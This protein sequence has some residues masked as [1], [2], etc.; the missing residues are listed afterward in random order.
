MKRV[1]HVMDSLER[2]GMETMLLSSHAEWLQSG[3]ECDVLATAPT[4]GPV[5]DQML[6]RGYGVFHIPLRG[7]QRYMPRSGS[8]REIY[9]LCRA[10][11]SVVHIHSES[12]PVVVAPLARLA[13]VGRIA[14]TPHNAFKFNGV[15]RTRKRLE[16]AFVRGLGGR[17]GMISE[18][19]RDCEWTRFRNAGVRTWNWIDTEHFR[20]PMLLQRAA[21]REAL[22]I[23]ED[24]FVT[25]SVGNCN[26][27]K[28][29]G[30]II[31]ALAMLQAERRMLHLHVG[32]EEPGAPERVL[33]GGLHAS[34][35]VRFVGSVLD[36]LPYLWASDAFLMPSLVEGLGLS[37]IEA[38]SAGV[39]LLCSAVEGLND[40][41]FE[42]RWT[43][44][45]GSD[46]ASIRD[47]IRH[48]WT[49]APDVLRERALEDSDRVRLR[50]S[51]QSGVRG[52][53]TGLYEGEARQEPLKVESWIPS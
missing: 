13:G 48:M 32:R 50:F 9:A 6:S 39:P 42:T 3:Y 41:I 25:V 19:V 53:V 5:A 12:A 51:P 8:L 36:P 28:N 7:Q 20:P 38:I 22:G 49:I 52:I 46:A 2:S 30:S 43:T 37:A 47:G 44:V 14:I 10:G 29:H 27:A 26:Q 1:L 11:Y 16:R 33:A 45:T 4:V 34:A 17:Y 23:A 40:V 15:L 31:R 18:G 35:A 24:V 21:A